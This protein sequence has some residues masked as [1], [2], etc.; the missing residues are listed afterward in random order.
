MNTPEMVVRIIY[1]EIRDRALAQEV[2]LY[3]L[4]YPEERKR[5]H[6]IAHITIQNGQVTIQ[7]MTTG[8]KHQEVWD[9][10][11]NIGVIAKQE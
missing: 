8:H 6:E 5:L 3:L 11:S 4:L 9:I 2:R 10:L 7:S 1:G